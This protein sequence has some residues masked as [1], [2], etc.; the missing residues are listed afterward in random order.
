MSLYNKCNK[1]FQN[2]FYN[3]SLNL[4]HKFI[5]KLEIFQ[6]DHKN[7]K[8]FDNLVFLINGCISVFVH[9]NVS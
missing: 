3:D 2:T 9:D 4:N 5:H 7:V 8:S 1:H 6:I